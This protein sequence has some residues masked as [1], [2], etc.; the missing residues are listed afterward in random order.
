MADATTDV[1]YQS[2]G[3]FYPRNL[4]NLTDLIT[5]LIFVFPMPES[6]DTN[7]MLIENYYVDD[8]QD[9]QEMGF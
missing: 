9:C 4:I 6:D 3:N 7:P 1:M 5:R 2:E 8:C